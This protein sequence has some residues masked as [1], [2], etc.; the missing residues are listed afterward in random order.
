[1]IDLSFASPFLFPFLRSWDTSLPSTG[2]DYVPITLT[3]V[4]PIS[5]PPPPVP[6]WSL[7]AWGSLSPVLS[8]LLIPP[9]PSLPTNT[10]MEVWFDTQLARVT[11]LLSSHTPLK[12]PSHRSK[13]W[14][15]PI[16]LVLRREFHAASR[17]SHSSASASNKAAARLSKQGYFKAIT[18]A[19]KA[20]WK[21]FLTTATPRSIWAVKTIAAGSHAPCFPNLPD[22]SSP[23]EMNQALLDHFF[24]PRPCAPLPSILLPFGD[25]P[26]LTKDDVSL[27][28]LTCSPSSAPGPDIIPYAVWKS[29]HRASPGGLVSLLAPLLRFGHQP[30]SLKKANGVVLD[31]PGKESYN[32]PA[33]FRIIV[34]LLTVSKIWERIVASRLAPIARYTGL[35]HR[36]QCGLLPSL[37]LFDACSALTDTVRTLQCPGRK[38]NMLFHDIKG[39]FDN[40][41][42][43]ILCSDLRPNG[44]N[45]YLVAW[46]RSFFSD[47]SSRLLFQGS[48]RVFSRLGWY[49]S[50]LSG[51]SPAVCYIRLTPPHPGSKRSNP[52]LRG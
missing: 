14:W 10:S 43:K 32:S 29:V 41:D 30:S 19:K 44:V 26:E 21:S 5:S 22:A 39:G 52:L 6:N 3:F 28:L 4:H 45:H 33:S 17:R 36:N 20:H 46:V 16:L 11:T 7:T 51:L 2:S 8:E 50:M 40:V 9:V 38:V 37:S 25:C 48:P 27:S 47:R 49:R 31:K 15:S 18:A 34:L 42:D 12:R 13:P 23:M 1:V 35:V 24:P